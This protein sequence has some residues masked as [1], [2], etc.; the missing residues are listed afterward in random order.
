M[1]YG[2]PKDASQSYVLHEG[3]IGVF[4]GTLQEAQLRRR[5]GTRREDG[6]KYTYTSTGGWMGISDKYWLVTQIPPQD[7]ALTSNAVLRSQ[8]RLLSGGFLPREPPGAGR[9]QR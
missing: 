7:E 4:D 1:R 2:T 9:R 6:A 5:P 3:P 8:G